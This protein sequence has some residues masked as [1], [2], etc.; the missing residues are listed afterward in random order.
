MNTE[1][2]KRKFNLSSKELN[3][4]LFILEQT[5]DV[6]IKRVEYEIVKCGDCNNCKF[7]S[8]CFLKGG[9]GN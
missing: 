4:A 9:K 8:F 2:L 7:G 6:N 3:L 1:E 5:S